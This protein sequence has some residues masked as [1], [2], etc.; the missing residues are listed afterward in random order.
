MA[1]RLHDIENQS[2]YRND[3]ISKHRKYTKW[4]T[5]IASFL[6]Y[7][8]DAIDFMCLALALPAIM[9][10]LHLT[11]A[12]AGLLGTAGMIGVGLSSVI[13]GW[14]SDNYGRRRA[15]IG[16]VLIFGIFTA[17]VSVGRNWTDLFVLRFL[18]GL[19][20]GGVWGVAMAFI[21]ET[22]PKEHRGRAASFVLS[23]WPIGFGCAALLSWWLLPLYGW[24]ALFLCGIGA[25]I[26][27]IYIY[28]FVPESEAWKRQKEEL[29]KKGEKE[30]I[31]ISEIFAPGVV[32]KTILGT[33]CA[34][35]ALT[36]YWGTNT[37]IPTYLVKERGLSTEDMTLFVVMLNIGMFIGYQIFGYLA[38]KIGR[39]KALILLFAC[40]T[41]ILPIYAMTKN[42]TLLFWMG[43]VVAIFFSY[44]GPFGSYFAELFP[45]RVRSLGAGFC[46]N[47][48]RG[49]AAFAPFALGALASHYSLS[50]GIALCAIGF[51]AA[52]II[53]L[54]LPETR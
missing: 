18:A 34:S 53:M 23:A 40:A 1:N 46:F 28:L 6:S 13:I 39:K 16:S 33:L 54:F 30:N 29:H 42:H 24:R 37:W 38:D 44:A 19:G 27:A 9:T 7:A 50:T 41:V 10:D 20:L 45:A 5:L 11:M 35:C 21:N 52:G 25:V 51:A 43:P 31:S 17:A 3:I 2:S 14:Y 47:V 12:D 32:M 22:W 15:L 26:A 4:H 49:I 36:A 8:F 48:G